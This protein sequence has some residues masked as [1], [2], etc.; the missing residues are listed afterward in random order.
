MKKLMD[1]D[2]VDIIP[3]SKGLIV[4]R[5]DVL[6]NGSVKV[7]FIGYDVKLERAAPVT[8]GVYLLNKFGPSYKPISEQI[9]DYVSCD[10]AILPNKHTAIVY[11]SGE[12]GI[13]DEKGTLYWTGD[14]FYKDCPVCSAAVENKYIWFVVPDF[15]CA[16]RYSPSAQKI[17][18]RIGADTSTAFSRP[19]SLSNYDDILYICNYGSNKIR[20]IS[21]RDYTVSDYKVFEEPVYKYIRTCD[22]EIAALNSGVYML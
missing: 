11:T 5:K 1:I 3:F 16:V 18:L 19:V 13:F 7:S 22:R 17:I 8:K 15:N 12:V 9:G 14:I 21:L 10:V 6:K 4:A 20:T 2:I